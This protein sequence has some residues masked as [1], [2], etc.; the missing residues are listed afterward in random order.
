MGEMMANISHQWKQPLNTI[1][2]SVVNARMSNKE[3]NVNYLASAIDDFMS[4]FDKKTHI[5]I[6]DLEDVLKEIKSIIQVHIANRGIGLYML[7]QI[8]QKIN[9]F[10]KRYKS[11]T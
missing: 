1:G 9:V 10:L 11:D 8:I 7:K 6:R 4:F 5:E 2:L 3:D